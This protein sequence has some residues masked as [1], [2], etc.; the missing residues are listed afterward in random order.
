MTDS[1]LV[2]LRILD[3]NQLYS[4]YTAVL[5]LQQWPV[6][7]TGREPKMRSNSHVVCLNRLV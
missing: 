3:R 2:C 1:V 6:N 4:N 5:R 7:D